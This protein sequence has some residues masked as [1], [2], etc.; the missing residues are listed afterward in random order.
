[1]YTS[2]TIPE[3][4]PMTDI[5]A[6]E[7][8]DFNIWT[9]DNTLKLTA[10]QHLYSEDGENPIATN[11]DSYTSLDIPLTDETRSLYDYFLPSEWT[12][13]LTTD[14]I[15]GVDDWTDEETLIASKHP[16]VLNWLATLPPYIPK[17][18]HNFGDGNTLSEPST[19][20]A[21]G[22]TYVMARAW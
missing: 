1:M 19:C 18:A 15:D 21:C 7:Y 14:N 17:V 20:T 4:M 16:V 3:A 8:Y 5:E 9:D 2:L 13:W 10:Y 6:T 22:V 12:E 11:T